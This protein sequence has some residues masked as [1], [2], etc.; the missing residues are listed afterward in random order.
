[1]ILQDMQSV[2]RDSGSLIIN[3]GAKA[4]LADTASHSKRGL[5][6]SDINKIGINRKQM[7]NTGRKEKA[8]KPSLLDV[9]D[10]VAFAE[11]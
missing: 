7:K 10:I 8:I 5:H 11:S 2:R 3:K 1:M 4:M 9:N 6:L